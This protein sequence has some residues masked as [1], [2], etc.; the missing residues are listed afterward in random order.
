[1]SAVT[2]AGCQRSPYELAPV[3]GKVTIDGRPVSQA[4]IMFA[5]VENA[6]NANPGKPAFGLLREDGSYALTTYEI[7]DGAVVGEH[8]VTLVNLAREARAMQ[9]KPERRST[10]VPS[11]SQISVPRRVTVVP[12]K[13]NQIDI[14]LTRREVA[15]YGAV[16][17]D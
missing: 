16:S 5:P 10:A 2:V 14:T 9:A 1:L 12:G 3:R 4:K 13:E 8:W 6:D 7:D 15:Q 17:D 11:F